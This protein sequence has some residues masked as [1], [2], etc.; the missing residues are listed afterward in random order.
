MQGLP[1]VIPWAG[2]APNVTTSSSLT[3]LREEEPAR[4]CRRTDYG[5]RRCPGSFRFKYCVSCINGAHTG[6][7]K[8]ISNGF[9]FKDAVL[10]GPS[11]ISPTIVQQFGYQRKAS[12]DGKLMDSS[13]TSSTIRV[14]LPN[15]QRTVV[16]EH[17]SEE[18]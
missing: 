5:T 3:R 1:E 16:R 7:W 14:F 18:M 17:S 12:D 6:A 13:K 10:D 9:G 8:T 2:E 15:K 11:C 4:H